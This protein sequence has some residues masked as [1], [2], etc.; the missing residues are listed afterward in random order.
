MFNNRPFIDGITAHVIKI[1][2]YKY[3]IACIV[4]FPLRRGYL[5]R[6]LSVHLTQRPFHVILGCGRSV[7]HGSYAKT[8]LSPG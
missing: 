2:Q 6:K 5:G 7:C 4:F 1:N 3:E 8:G